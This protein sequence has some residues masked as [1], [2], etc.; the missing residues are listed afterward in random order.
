MC[1]KRRDLI[2]AIRNWR[3]VPVAKW[4]T[5]LPPKE[6]IAGSIP[7]RDA[8]DESCPTTLCSPKKKQASRFPNLEKRCK[9]DT[10]A[11]WL[12]RQPAK[13]MGFARVGLNPIG[14]VF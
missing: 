7:A 13:L 8:F 9:N 1:P 3:N 14:V 5:R 10:V 6:K 11:E 4:I 2:Y 12:R